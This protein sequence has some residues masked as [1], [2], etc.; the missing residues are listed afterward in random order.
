V[1]VHLLRSAGNGFYATSHIHI[2]FVGDDALRSGCNGLQARRA[3]A[4]DGHARYADRAARAQCDLP[5]DVS[6]GCALRR[7]A[8]HDDIVH[9][10][11]LDTCALY[12]VFDHVSAHGGAMG[13]VK[14]ALPAFGQ[15][16]AGGGN[17]YSSSHGYSLVE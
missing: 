3:K 11:G 15:G 7:A 10:G 4:V 16:R 12:G 6:A 5:C 8:T 17:N 2:A 1:L 9:F 13:H 14:G